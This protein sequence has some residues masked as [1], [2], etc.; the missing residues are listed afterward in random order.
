MQKIENHSIILAPSILHPVI[1]KELLHNKFGIMGI[2]LSTIEGYFLS[3]VP[4]PNHFDDILFCYRE[5]MM[6]MQASLHIFHDVCLQDYFL[7]EC[8]QFIDD[9]KLHDICITSLPRTNQEEIELANIL[10]VL[11]GIPTKMDY[12]RSA[13]DH[14]SS[15]QK[16]YIYPMIMKH[17]EQVL[18]KQLIAHQAVVLETITYDPKTMF[19]HAMNRRE[20]V[21]GLAQYI[22]HHEMDVHD[23][24]IMICNPQYKHLIQ[25]IFN[26][27]NIPFTLLSKPI[28]HLPAKRF[29]VLLAFYLQPDQEHF[30]ALLDHMMIKLAHISELKE[31]MSLFEKNWQD[32]FIDI[33]E[34]SSEL[35]SSYELDKL[36][37][38]R[39]HAIETQS[40]IRVIL[41]PLI[42]LPWQEAL[43]EIDRMIATS[44]SSQHY[45]DLMHL[46]QYI[47]HVFPH[48]HSHDDLT[49][50]CEC[51]KKK[52]ASIHETQLQGVLIHDLKT[53][54]PQ[55]KYHV[56]LGA[57]QADYPA[58]SVKKGIFDEAYY[59]KTS[60][61]TL[62]KRYDD[63]MKQV[64]QQLAISPHLIISYPL[65]NFEGKGN[66]AALEIESFVKAKAKPYPIQ[67]TYEKYA[68]MHSI[69]PLQAKLLYMKEDILHASISSLEKYIQ[70]PFAYYLRYGLRLKEPF[71]L[72]FNEGKIGT[73]AHHI[74][75]QL[76]KTYGKQYCDTKMDTIFALLNQEIQPLLTLYPNRIHW[77]DLLKQR[78]LLNIEQNLKVLKDMEDHSEMHILKSEYEFYR[79]YSIK[80]GVLRLH[81]FIDRID[82]KNEF[83]RIIDYKSS[84]KSLNE[85]DVFAAVQLQLITYGIISQQQFQKKL[86]GTHYVSLKNE[87]ISYEAGKIKRRPVEYIPFQDQDYEETFY[88]T[89][90]MQGW[91]MD[92]HLEILDDNGAHVVGISMNKSG[93]VKA[94]K[95]YHMD[96]LKEHF[97]TMYQTIGSKI[98]SG[99]ISLTP[100]EHACDYCNYH[101]I[102]RFK[103]LATKKEVLIELDDSIYVER[104]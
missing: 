48:L 101:E 27:Y 45:N 89:H 32:D 70:C 82:E 97:E 69:T 78:M 6:P 99:N 83:I 19:Y 26:R 60:Y 35:I 71:Q 4:H 77:F 51:L 66:E 63:D 39:K 49:F 9:I 20:E 50:L 96:T 43:L 85:K 40:Q 24:N 13:F 53:L 76:T 8:M 102:C 104:K 90:R 80:E 88:Q 84:P 68:N 33:P 103:G 62:Q 95:L 3:L 52:S 5:L 87:N 12:I 73:L 10:D 64:A 98:L 58:I 1:Q 91:N 17:S 18:V 59:A 21:E 79:D 93:E 34:L 14:L 54:L 31:Y 75:E 67:Y 94:R 55:R 81:G 23:M 25:Q 86:L 22:I 7:Q 2:R 46:Q 16:I 100:G 11:Y 29:A 37:D 74:L 61:P 47:Q 30:I 56:I 92:E 28:Q 36:R 41:E 44:L 65:G 57:T 15:Q 72:S 42:A 38:I